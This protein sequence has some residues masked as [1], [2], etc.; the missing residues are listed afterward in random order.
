MN[1]NTNHTYHGITV[2]ISNTPEIHTMYEIHTMNTVRATK[3]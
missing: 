2:H 3:I 1:I